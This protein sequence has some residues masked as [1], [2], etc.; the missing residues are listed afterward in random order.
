[1]SVVLLAV[2]SVSIAIGLFAMAYMVLKQF[3]DHNRHLSE[4]M[5]N[6]QELMVKK[7]DADNK[8]HEK[9]AAISLKLQAY[10]RMVLFLERINPPNLLIRVSPGN[11]R[12]ADLQNAL[13]KSI[14]EEY[15][16]NLTQQLFISAIAWELV[17]NAKEEV[18]KS[19]NLAAATVKPDDPANVYA[20]DI[21][22][23]WF[24]N[25]EDAVEKAL[26]LLKEDVRNNF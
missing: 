15:E 5:K 22:T 17:K 7:I 20:Q 6:Y 18:V 12:A 8:Q 26:N 4:Q 9:K 21:M 23:K 13:L 16:H 24:S 11:K 2:I 19:V 3:A 14:R 10:E 1:M 25:K